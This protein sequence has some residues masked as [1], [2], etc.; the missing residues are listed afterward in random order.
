MEPGNQAG[1]E[2]LVFAFTAATPVKAG[3]APG[4]RVVFSVTQPALVNGAPAQLQWYG[5]WPLAPDALEP[6][7][8]APNAPAPNVLAIAGDLTQGTLDTQVLGTLVESG[9]NGTVLQREVPGRLQVKWVGSGDLAST[10]VADS[11]Q[12]AAYTTAL[13][14]VG[15]GRLALASGTITVPALGA[16][17]PIQSSASL[18][19]STASLAAVA[20]GLVSVTMQ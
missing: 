18:A 9:A 10:T 17:I 11:F 4:P 15:Q 8:L 6:S 14:I 3:A 2:A 16:P 5:D 19:S 20:T 13:Q 12:T 1:A 7:V